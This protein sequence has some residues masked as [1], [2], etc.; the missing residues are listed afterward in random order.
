MF[1]DDRLH[2]V[3]KRF[4]R[5]ARNAEFVLQQLQHRLLKHR[6]AG[7][8]LLRFAHQTRRT[9]LYSRQT[10]TSELT[11]FESSEVP[12]LLLATLTTQTFALL[13]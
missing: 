2:G 1:V 4:V 11:F 13:D 10:T 3:G 9:Q 5:A 8:R 6:G 7:R 12:A